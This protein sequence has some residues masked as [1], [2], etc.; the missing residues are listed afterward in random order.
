MFDVSSTK[1]C[2]IR[3]KCTELGRS[4]SW[5]LLGLARLNPGIFRMFLC[6]DGLRHRIPAVLQE[7][8]R[9]DCDLR[10]VDQPASKVSRVELEQYKSIRKT[11]GEEKLGLERSEAKTVIR[12]W[13]VVWL[14]D[15]SKNWALKEQ[16]R[17][18]EDVPLLLDWKECSRRKCT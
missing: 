1:S 18:R 3:K 12:R 6:E 5:C 13:R 8:Q 14:E 2:D 11:L 10:V 4:Q 16:T 7:S 17:W 15:L 9:R